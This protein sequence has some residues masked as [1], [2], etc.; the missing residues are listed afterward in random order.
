MVQHAG[1]LVDLR[2][3][4]IL[5]SRVDGDPN[6]LCITSAKTLDKGIL[7]CNSNG[8]AEDCKDHSFPCLSITRKVFG[9]VSLSG[10][11]QERLVPKASRITPGQKE[12]GSIARRYTGYQK[13]HQCTHIVGKCGG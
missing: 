11:G 12:P 8:I 2:R 1:Q 6:V 4:G 13:I 10:F 7:G 9:F 5:G 3:P